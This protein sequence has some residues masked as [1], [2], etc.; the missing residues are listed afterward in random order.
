MA[1]TLSRPLTKIERN[2]RI[3]AIVWLLL[4]VF[5]CVMYGIFARTNASDIYATNGVHEYVVALASAGCAIIGLGGL[6]TYVTGLKWSGFGFAFLITVLCYQYYFLANAF[7]TKANLQDT[8]TDINGFF[9]PRQQYGQRFSMYV[10][11]MGGTAF[12]TF[13]LTATQAFKMAI[14]ITVAFSAIVGRAGPLEILI[15]VLVGG[16]VYELNRQ[17]ISHTMYD[18]GGSNTIFLFGGIMGTFVSFVLTLFTQKEDVVKRSNYTSSRFNATL[19]LVGAGFWWVLYP[20][21]LLDVPFV[22]SIASGL[23]SPFLEINGMVSAYWGI[24]ACVVTSLALSAAING[25][26]RIKDLLYAP[27]AGAAFVG[28]SATHMFTPVEAVLLGMIAGLIQPIFN[29]FE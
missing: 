11:E 21:T 17:I 15:F 7:W 16:A 4:E 6:M 1:E 8:T 3:F 22:I 24:S 23:F 25:R 9:T 13:G 26:I 10:S 27:F 28:T 19:A 20:A 5:F 18:V 29:I 14:S 12:K 2:N